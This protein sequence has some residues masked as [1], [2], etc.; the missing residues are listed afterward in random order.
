MFVVRTLEPPKHGEKQVSREFLSYGSSLTQL[1][2]ASSQHERKRLKKKEYQKKKNK[3]NRERAQTNNFE[4]MLNQQY[5]EKINE[6]A[7]P[8]QAREDEEEEQLERLVTIYPHFKSHSS[9]LED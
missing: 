1:D 2:P 7:D 5:E 6:S 3:Q 8:A 4:K 9:R